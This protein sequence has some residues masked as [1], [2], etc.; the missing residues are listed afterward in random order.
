MYIVIELQKTENALSHLETT[1]ENRDEAESKF[2]EVLKYAAISSIPI[3]SAV[4]LDDSGFLI[5]TESYPH[6]L[7]VE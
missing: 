7:P 6:Q 1:F 5:R 4:M 3:H 2:H